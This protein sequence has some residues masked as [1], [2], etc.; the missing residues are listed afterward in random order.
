MDPLP[1]FLTQFVWFFVAWSTLAYLVVWPWSLRLSAE[2]GLMVWIAPQ[3]FRAF[4]LGLLVPALSP[5]LAPA[6]AVPVAAFDAFTAVLALLAFI[7]LRRGRRAARP[8][9][10]GA[11]VIGLSDLLI[12]FSIAPF[13]GVADHL[14]GQWYIPAFV[15]PL[16]IVAHVGCLAALLRFGAQSRAAAAL[17]PALS[18]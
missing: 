1:L 17:E 4:G 3:M 11:T 10:W 16:L 8:L 9:T 6:F 18:D 15:G 12:A 13:I 2:T 5:G 14:A 7:A